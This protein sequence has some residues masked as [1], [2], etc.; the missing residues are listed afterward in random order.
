MAGQV[1]ATNSEG[2]YLY[3]DELSD[4]LRVALQPTTKF[5]QLADADDFTDKGYHVGDTVHWDIVT[6]VTTEGT[7]LTEGV[8]IPETQ[9]TVYQGTATISEWGNSVPYTSKLDD[10]SY[11]PI[12]KIVKNALARDAQKAFD[13]AVFNQFALS[14][15]RIVGTNGTDGNLVLTT[16]GTATATNNTELTKEHWKTAI[17]LMKERN[18]PP[19]AGDD[20]I[21]VARPTNFRPLMDDLESVFQYTDE[22]FNRIVRGQKGRYYGARAVEQTFIGAAAI[23]NGGTAWDNGGDWAI[24]MGADTVAEIIVCPEEIRGKI[25]SDFGRSKGVAWYAELGYS[26]IHKGDGTQGRV[27]DAR[28]LI[29]DSA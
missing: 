1:W 24:F 7:T 6:D 26:L 5:R 28:I 10:L 18:I 13:R 19:F 23:G 25:P 17:D 9:F 8:T 15:L 20:Y 3:S 16:N 11:F 22:G 4:D 2:G 21:V 14:K 29:W 12:Q 27:E